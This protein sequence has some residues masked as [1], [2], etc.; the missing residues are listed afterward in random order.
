M[1]SGTTS[2]KKNNEIDLEE[3]ADKLDNMLREMQSRMIIDGDST[4]GGLKNK[5]HLFK[6]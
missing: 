6:K 2:K 5:F 4:F 1:K 3:E